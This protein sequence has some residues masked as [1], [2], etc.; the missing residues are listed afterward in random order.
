MDARAYFADVRRASIE[1]EQCQR[2]INLLK[3]G[4]LPPRA[5]V[6]GA[7]GKGNHSD[8]TAASFVAMV[9]E[10]DKAVKRRDMCTELIGEALVIIESLR[11]IYSAKA[12]VLELYYIDCLSWRDVASRM[13]I[14]DS[15]ARFWANQLFDWL[16]SCPTA[17]IMACRYIDSSIV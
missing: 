3:S 17:Y 6:D 7:H 16:D 1:V 15:T 10:M 5:T 4:E 9:E 11:K 8:P 12:D 2:I 14:A 13:H